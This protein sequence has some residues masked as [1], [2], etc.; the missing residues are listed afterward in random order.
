MDKRKIERNGQTLN[1][2][3][4]TNTKKKDTDKHEIEIKGKAQNR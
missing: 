4:R 3:K 1:R 2:N